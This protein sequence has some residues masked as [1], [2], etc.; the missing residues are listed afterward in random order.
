MA[1]ETVAG[2][3]VVPVRSVN[4]A[5]NSG[6]VSLPLA[7]IS[8]R[9]IFKAPSSR[10]GLRPPPGLRSFECLRGMAELL[11][12]NHTCPKFDRR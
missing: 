7:S 2:L 5:A 9:S 12:R 10:I 8:L 3:M 4:A 6:N 1:D 11:D